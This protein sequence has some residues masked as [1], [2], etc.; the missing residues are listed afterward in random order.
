MNKDTNHD[1]KLSREECLINQ[2]DAEVATQRFQR[3][4]PT[5]AGFLSHSTSLS[6]WAASRNEFG[7]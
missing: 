3:G 4:D 6:T 2:N 5:K 1:G 7:L